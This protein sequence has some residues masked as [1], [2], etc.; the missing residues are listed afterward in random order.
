VRYLGSFDTRYHIRG[1]KNASHKGI[2]GWNPA[3]GAITFRMA[4]NAHACCTVPD[5]VVQ[6]ARAQLGIVGVYWN[7]F[8]GMFLYTNKTLLVTIFQSNS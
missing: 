6:A 5:S 7:N 3:W 4:M 8:P 2:P 1:S